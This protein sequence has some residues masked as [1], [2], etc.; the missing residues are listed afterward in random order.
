MGSANCCKKPDEI[1][2]EE[3]AGNNDNEYPEDTQQNHRLN[4]NEQEENMKVS[5][6]SNQ[7]LYEHDIAS[8]KIGGAYEVPINVSSPQNNY[9]QGE[10]EEAYEQNEIGSPEQYEQNQVEEVNIN[11]NQYEIE[12]KNINV[13]ENSNNYNMQE[14]KASN[15]GGLDLN[16]L[17][18]VNASQ[19]GGVD[20]NNLAL[21]NQGNIGVTEQQTTTTTT[22]TTNGPVDLNNFELGQQSANPQVSTNSNLNKYFEKT[23]SQYVSV[24]SQATGNNDASKFIQSKTM[25]PSFIPKFFK[26]L[27]IVCIVLGNLVFFIISNSLIISPKTLII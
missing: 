8:P 17:S 3:I 10:G 11:Q 20:L 18:N 6:T 15:V 12:D 7:N 14:S 22:T 5:A 4:P 21:R 27:F 19:Q 23:T 25:S 24:N 1:V 9:M 13:I 2:I 26:S 16:S